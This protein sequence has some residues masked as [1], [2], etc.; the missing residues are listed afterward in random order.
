MRPWTG[1]WPFIMVGSGP[2][3]VGAISTSR[4]KIPARRAAGK[5]DLEMIDQCLEEGA[6]ERR[7][8]GDGGSRGVA[9]S[10]PVADHHAVPADA[11]SKAPELVAGRDS[12]QR[13]EQQDRLC[14]IRARDLVRN[15]DG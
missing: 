7:V 13:G 15:R 10:R 4:L 2:R 5:L 12:A 3:Q 9:E 6:T 8:V 1:L 14:A 11:A